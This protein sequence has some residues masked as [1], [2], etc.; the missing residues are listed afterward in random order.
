MTIGTS[1]QI[2]YEKRRD[3]LAWVSSAM[4]RAA[5][6]T[7]YYFTPSKPVS[8]RAHH[9]YSLYLENPQILKYMREHV[10]DRE[11]L[12]QMVPATPANGI[13]EEATT[14]EEFILD[15]RRKAGFS[16][17]SKEDLSS[18]KNKKIATTLT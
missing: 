13:V 16:S 9:L 1:L 4:D 5:N 6:A 11:K 7:H 3:K 15:G 18:K 17:L 12:N 2:R 10:E 8:S 14:H